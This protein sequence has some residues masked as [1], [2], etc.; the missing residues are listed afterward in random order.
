MKNCA[1][2]VSCHAHYAKKS[3]PQNV[4]FNYTKLDVKKNL[5]KMMQHTE[6]V[7]VYSLRTKQN[8]EGMSAQK[9]SIGNKSLRIFILRIHIKN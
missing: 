8:E 2:T 9:K 4:T 1:L 7:D 6:G 5:V 3:F